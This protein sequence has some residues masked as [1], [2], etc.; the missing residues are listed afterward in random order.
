METNMPDGEEETGDRA[1]EKRRDAK[2]WGE[3]RGDR[4]RNGE[5]KDDMGLFLRPRDYQE[6]GPQGPAASASSRADRYTVTFVPR[7]AQSW[8][9]KHE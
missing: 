6:E 9:E 7:A 1:G 8:S 4:E 3:K 5:P 2:R